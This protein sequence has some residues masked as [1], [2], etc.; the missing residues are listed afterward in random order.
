MRLSYV[1]PIRRISP[2]QFELFTYLRWLSG[3]VEVIVVDGSPGPVF[4]VH[5]AC[6]LDAVVHVRLD[7]DLSGCANGKAAGAITG[8]RH[9]TAEHVIIADE[10]VRYDE[11]GLRAVAR[12]LERADVVRP[13]NY[14][15]PLPWH[16]CVD[17][18]RTLINRVTGGDWPGTLGVRRSVL[19][20][21]G[22]Y[23]GNVLFENLELIRTVV[24]AGGREAT[25]LDLYVRR[26]PPTTRHFWSQRVRQAYDEFARPVRLLVWLTVAPATAAL[27]LGAHWSWLMGAAACTIV[28]A[29]TG[30]RRGGGRRVFP[31]VASFAAPLWIAERAV[32][33]W[34]AVAAYTLWGGVPYRGRIVAR[35]ATPLRDIQAR[36]RRNGVMARR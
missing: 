27:A 36:L 15:H 21:I 12:E 19:L 34:L 2:A 5:T 13:Q 11:A 35:A 29:E 18:A 17:T 9:A 1:L 16:C 14:F 28:A 30:R 10:D 3:W 32:S 8:L 25:P 26:L 4:A 20:S 31:I 7:P 33:A 24:A 6:C 22:G 23:D